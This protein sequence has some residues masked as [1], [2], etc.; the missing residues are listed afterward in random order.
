[1]FCDFKPLD[2][3]IGEKHMRVE[4]HPILGDRKPAKEVIIYFDGQPIRALEGE[5]I[6][7]ALYQAGIRAF[8]LTAKR[9]EPRGIFCAIGRC[10]DCMM[11]VDGVANT[12][13]CVTPVRDGMRVETQIGNGRDAAV[14]GKKNSEERTENLIRPEGNCWTDEAGSGE[15]IR[16]EDIHRQDGAG[17][18]EPVRADDSGSLSE[19]MNGVAVRSEENLWTDE[20]KAQETRE[21]GDFT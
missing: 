9:G 12:R 17:S 15:A 20:R 7:A 2:F 19:T 4:H 6:A 1:L 3:K 18:G 8:R 10:T 13:T 21:E 11:I 5:M 14:R 16:M